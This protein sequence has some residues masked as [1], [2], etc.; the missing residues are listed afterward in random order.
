MSMLTNRFANINVSWYPCHMVT[1]MHKMRYLIK[2]ADCIFELRDARIPISSSNP[3]LSQ[4]LKE[5]GR[6]IPNIVIYNKKDLADPQSNALLKKN[7]DCVLM[8]TDRMSDIDALMHKLIEMISLEAHTTRLMIIGIPNVGKSTLIN[9]LRARGLKGAGKGVPTGA[10]P[11]VTRHAGQAV[12]IH[13][14]PDVVIWDTPGITIPKFTDSCVGLR[15]AITGGIYDRVIGQQV[16]A[17]FIL[18]ELNRLNNLDYVT[19]CGLSDKTDSLE[20]IINQGAR[21]FKAYLT[22]G[23][24]DTQRILGLFIKAFREGKLGRVTLDDLSN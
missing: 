4:L 16:L 24:P 17:D 1:A 23:I 21:R 14:N 11:G 9:C 22:G 2:R 5:E 6:N 8:C 7:R 15:M 13:S 12:K 3:H 10:L 18:Y 19:Y 20:D